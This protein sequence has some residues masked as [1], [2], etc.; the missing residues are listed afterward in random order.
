MSARKP[1]ATTSSTT[2]TAPARSRRGRRV[3]V[4]VVG[5][6]A[7]GAAAIALTPAA[8]AATHAAVKA[9]QLNCI[10]APSKCGYPDATNTGVPAGTTLLAVPGQLTSGPGWHYDSRGW[11]EVTGNGAVLSGLAISTNLD[12]SASNVT[13]Q[14]VKVTNSGQSSLGISLRHTV[15]VTIEHST[16]T[17]LNATSGRLMVGVKDAYGDS[18]GLKVLSSNIFMVG[19]G[20]QTES[21]LIQG[22]YI[23]DI[24]Y[25]PGD[26]LDGVHSDG[27][28]TSPLTITGNTILMDHNQTGAVVLNED[29]GAQAN[30]VVSGNL[31]AGGGYTIYAGGSSGGPVSTSIKF[32]DNRVSTQYYT[33]GGVFG[34]AAH[35]D[36][37]GA[38]N[39]WTANTWDNTGQI[40][41]SP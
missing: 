15:G 27:G 39:S 23:H 2:T 40:I 8:F 13:I 34:P 18:T 41:P 6:G 24:G 16:I 12:I 5:A 21:G 17:G 28:G 25:I 10:A 37:N 26:H 20:V 38:G 36:T 4:A 22:N 7:L 14:N 31:L 19:T 11:V 3:A 9:S 30:R 1:T 35:Y 33:A 32:S 29:N